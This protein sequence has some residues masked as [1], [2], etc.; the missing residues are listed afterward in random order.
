MAK[1]SVKHVQID[2]SQS[3]MLAVVALTVVVVVFGLFATKAMVSK[4]LYQRR[5]L[6]ARREVVGKLKDNYQA[7]QTL[8]NQYSVFAKANPNIIDG[9]IDGQSSQ[10]GDNAKIV[11]DALPDTYDAP[12]LASS[13]EKLL[14]G[15]TLSIESLEI[16]DDPATYSAQPEAQPQPKTIPF[17]F[18][19]SATFQTDALLLQDFEKSIRPFDVNTLEL[20]GTDSD[21][22]ISVTMTTYYQPATSL[23]LQ[24]T[25]VVQ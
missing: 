23:D 4:G 19:G 14:L 12:A 8:F 11:L 9:T 10:D 1:M 17:S 5:A 16:T 7:A 22:K 13:V 24:A 21:L 3:T 15:R 6:S 25:K 2:K 18:T 20:D